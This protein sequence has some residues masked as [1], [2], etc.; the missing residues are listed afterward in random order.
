MERFTAAGV[1]LRERPRRDVG[2]PLQRENTMQH[3]KTM[4]AAGA[5]MLI[6]V[7]SARAV[8]QMEGA[9]ASAQRATSW[10]AKGGEAYDA[11]RA[12]ADPA[13]GDASGFVTRDEL[14]QHTR[15]LIER[16]DRERNA[17]VAAPTFTD[18]G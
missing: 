3:W 14:E 18:A 12:K 4:M 15:A 13:N 10:D 9:T 2:R 1:V 16:L 7:G 5:A 8:E 17:R 6:S 11:A